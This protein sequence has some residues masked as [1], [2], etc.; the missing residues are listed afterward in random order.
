MNPNDI[1]TIINSIF[2]LAMPLFLLA[3]CLFAIGQTVKAGH[4][5]AE[6]LLELEDIIEHAPHPQAKD[7]DKISARIDYLE[8]TEVKDPLLCSA[9]TDL[10]HRSQDYHN[11]CWLYDPASRLNENDLLTT[12]ENHIIKG[13]YSKIILF[14]PLVNCS[15]CLFFVPST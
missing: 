6:Q 1:S 5:S 11:N 9:L 2:I 3:F 10:V 13:L 14:W 8:Q 4:R 7:T 12:H 15:S